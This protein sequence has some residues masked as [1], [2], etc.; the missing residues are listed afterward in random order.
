MDLR[1]QGSRH[2]AE[3]RNAPPNPP[4][5]N[6]E[7]LNEKSNYGTPQPRSLM[8][9]RH[10]RRS[11]FVLFNEG[12]WNIWSRRDAADDGRSPPSCSR[13]PARGGPTRSIGGRPARAGRRSRLAL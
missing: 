5:K 2:H 4:S 13:Q 8:S 9:T 3:L 12:S 1:T 7:H 6:G 11:F 10:G